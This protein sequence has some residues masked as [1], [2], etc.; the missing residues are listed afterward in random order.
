MTFIC[1]GDWRAYKILTTII[2]N[3]NIHHMALKRLIVDAGIMSTTAYEKGLKLLK[4]DNRVTITKDKNKLLYDIARIE[5]FSSPMVDETTKATLDILEKNFKARWE[6]RFKQCK[7][8]DKIKYAKTTLHVLQT[9]RNYLETLWLVRYGVPVKSDVQREIILKINDLCI[10][11]FKIISNDS[12]DYRINFALTSDALYTFADSKKKVITLLQEWLKILLD[13]GVAHDASKAHPM[14]ELYDKIM[15][16]STD[17]EKE[18]I[19]K[20][21]SGEIE[22][23]AKDIEEYL[24]KEKSAK[25]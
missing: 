6:G 24:K 19:F 14:K 23:K 17:E 18:I 21:M 8:K 10:H 22:P 25:D 20:L 5:Y 3:P 16:C 12:E 9:A 1:D 15:V 4:N 2:E 7:L 13:M 11:V